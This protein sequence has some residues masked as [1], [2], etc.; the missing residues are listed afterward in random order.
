MA[1]SWATDSLTDLLNTHGQ[2]LP[3]APAPEDF[4][5]GTMLAGD[6]S[7][8]VG[9]SGGH[10]ML[11]GVSWKWSDHSVAGGWAT[12]GAKA[13]RTRN[14]LGPCTERILSLGHHPGSVLSKRDREK[15]IWGERKSSCFF[16]CSVFGAC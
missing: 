6:I 12:R 7:P 9:F 5:R 10:W 1:A 2:S 8:R 15:R 3:W 16:R 4:L 13:G 14:L 11:T